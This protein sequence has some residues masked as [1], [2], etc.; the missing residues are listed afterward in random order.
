MPPQQSFFVASFKI[1]IEDGV[2]A[3]V[4]F[5]VKKK[6]AKQFQIQQH[7]LLEEKGLLNCLKIM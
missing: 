2:R 4:F 6:C 3:E 7:H 1:Q 5:D